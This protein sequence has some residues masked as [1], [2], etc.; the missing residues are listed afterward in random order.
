MSFLSFF[1][2][3]PRPQKRG[4]EEQTKRRC[5]HLRLC[6]LFVHIAVST[7]YVSS[8]QAFQNPCYIAVNVVYLRDLRGLSS[9]AFSMP[10]TL[11]SHNMWCFMPVGE[12]LI[13]KQTFYSAFQ[14]SPEIKQI[15]PWPKE[16]F[17]SCCAQELQCI[18]GEEETTD[19]PGTKLIPSAATRCQ[20]CLEVE[21]TG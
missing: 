6:R 16:V 15:Q 17:F 5:K 7:H 2:F 8:A 3:W 14:D 1:L 21:R 19:M 12:L 18:Q 20:S 10:V 11:Q 9:S 4:T 13:S